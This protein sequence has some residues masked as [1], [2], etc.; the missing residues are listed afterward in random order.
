VGAVGQ[1]DRG[2]GAGDLLHGHDVFEIAEAEAAVFF[3]D[4]D[5]VQAQLAHFGPELALEGV[6]LV[7]LG[8]QGRQGDRSP[9]GRWSRGSCRRFRR[10]RIPWIGGRW[11]SGSWLEAAIEATRRQAPN[12]R[13]II[14]EGTQRELITL[15]GRGRLDATIAVAA[16]DSRPRQTL[17]SESY[18]VTLPVG[19][20]FAE[21]QSVKAEDL[22]GETMIVRRHCE[23]L[24]D[25]SRHFTQ[26]GVRPFMAARTTS[27]DRALAYVRAGLGITVMPQCFGS[28]GVAMPLLAGFN[29]RRRIGILIEPDSQQRVEK[30]S[31]YEVFG[32]TYASLARWLGDR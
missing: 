9:S 25:T 22:G 2:G 21:T 5:A 27:D 7:D 30:T 16:P 11:E 23:A 4:G 8:G 19:H 3:L 17:F 28:E 31:A 1:A 20:R 14:T 12:E 26:A 15:L 18:A 10:G 24:A 29:L 13:L 32:S 6:G